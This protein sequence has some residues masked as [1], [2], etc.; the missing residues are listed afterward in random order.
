[1]YIYTP[2][3]RICLQLV[4][5]K[6]VLCVLVYPCSFPANQDRPWR[7]VGCRLFPRPVKSVSWWWWLWEWGCLMRRT[8]QW[9]ENFLRRCLTSLQLLSKCKHP[10]LPQILG[11]MKNSW[12]EKNFS[13][14]THISPSI[15][16]T[17]WYWDFHTYVRDYGEHSNFLNMI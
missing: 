10:F 13:G 7:R 4:L 1:M 8:L 14:H 17:W 11:P 15:I 5:T 16:K 6:P 3:F 12:E 9:V 2:G